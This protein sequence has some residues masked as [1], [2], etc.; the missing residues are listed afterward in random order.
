MTSF[1]DGIITKFAQSLSAAS[2]LSLVKRSVAKAL[3]LSTFLCTSSCCLKQT[4]P[5]VC[6]FQA[7]CFFGRFGTHSTL[8]VHMYSFTRFNVG[9]FRNELCCQ[10]RIASL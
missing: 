5:F 3:N 9:A 1:Y 4:L 8:L 2:A 10:S 6:I 7:N